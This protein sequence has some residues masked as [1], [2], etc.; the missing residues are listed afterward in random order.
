MPIPV[1]KAPNAPIRSQAI[2]KKGEPCLGDSVVAVS[3]VGQLL[4][5]EEGLNSKEVT[6][7]PLRCASPPGMLRCCARTSGS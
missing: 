5:P 1:A 3:H 4:Q 7:S 6:R 2:V